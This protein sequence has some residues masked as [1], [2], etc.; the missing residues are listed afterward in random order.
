MR[1]SL[2]VGLGAS[3]GTSVHYASCTVGNGVFSSLLER[4]LYSGA[5]ASFK[6]CAGLV[7]EK[8]K[9]LSPLCG[10]GLGEK[11]LQAVDAAAKMLHVASDGKVLAESNEAEV[12]RTII[13][14]DSVPSDTLSSFELPKEGQPSGCILKIVHGEMDV[15]EC[16]QQCSDDS[17]CAA[18]SFSP[19]YSNFCEMYDS[20]SC[21]VDTCAWDRLYY[22][23]KS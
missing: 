9:I 22:V 1:A 14:P 7:V 12:L 23:K 6:S 4:S 17:S 8:L 3:P 15:E 10:N 11:C 2:N 19:T 20:T 21:T 5:R 18:F 13:M 16:S